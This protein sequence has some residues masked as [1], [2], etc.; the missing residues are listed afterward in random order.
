M[1]IL[2]I[3]C[4]IA[5]ALTFPTS[6]N[7]QGKGVAKKQ[8]QGKSQDETAIRNKCRAETYGYGVS[9]AA[10]FRACVQRAKGR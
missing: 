5:A 4:I 6:V 9:A 3:F 2:A 8:T 1:R 10:Q 7:A